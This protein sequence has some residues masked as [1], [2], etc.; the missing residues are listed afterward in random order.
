MEF[1]NVRVKMVNRWPGHATRD[2]KRLK[3]AVNANS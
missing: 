1:Q 3:E 2:Y